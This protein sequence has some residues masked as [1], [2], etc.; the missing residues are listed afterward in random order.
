VLLVLHARGDAMTAGELA[1]RFSCS[2]PTVTRHLQRLLDA[3]LVSVARH[4]RERRYTLDVDR[5]R[6]V[7]SLYLGV[8]D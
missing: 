3:R 4:G 8:F 7:T 1:D 5:L 2:W 6:E